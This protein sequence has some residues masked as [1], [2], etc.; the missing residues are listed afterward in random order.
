MDNLIFKM[1]VIQKSLQI[2]SVNK[3]KS[4]IIMDLKQSPRGNITATAM[5]KKKH[6]QC[7]VKGYSTFFGNR[8]I[9]P[10]PRVKQL[11]FTVFACIETIF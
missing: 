1:L 4:T 9:L 10:L 2:L 8:L 11:S 5:L 3:H 7:H 6:S